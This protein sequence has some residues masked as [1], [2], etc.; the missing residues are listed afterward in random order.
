MSLSLIA[1]KLVLALIL[2]AL[3]YAIWQTQLGYRSALLFDRSQVYQEAWEED[4]E[5]LT[6]ENW[7][8]AEADLQAA[9]RLNENEAEY[10]HKY[11]LLIDAE[12]T[13]IGADITPGQTRQILVNS[14]EA[15]RRG[16]QQRP[17]SP[18]G[19]AHLSRVKALAGQLDA[20]F[21]QAMERMDTL[22]PWEK[23][24]HQ[25][26]A[27]LSQYYWLRFSVTASYYAKEILQRALSNPGYDSP[28]LRVLS[29]S[30]FL[31]GQLCP[32][33]DLAIL[34]EAAQTACEAEEVQ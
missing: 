11:G 32:A 10:L 30:E 28:V 33:L 5:L 22:G 17:S 26:T 9:L 24:I 19:W 4:P 16:V 8:A 3:G 15:H 14:I 20:E 31:Q 25:L 1:K 2:I 23:E 27:Y 29:G 34:T 7:Q 13:L 18:Y 6:V 21:D 12:R